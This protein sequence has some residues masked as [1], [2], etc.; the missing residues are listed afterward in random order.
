MNKMT[1]K[2]RFIKT[3]FFAI[4]LI[5]LISCGGKKE[6]P[7]AAYYN[8]DHGLPLQD[9]LL[10]KADSGNYTTLKV[11]FNSVHDKTVYGL[12]SLPENAKKPLP[13]IIL[14]HGVGDRKTVDYIES[15]NSYF[16]EAGYAVFRIDIAN[17]GERKTQN[18]EVDFTGVY[19]YWTRDILSQ[20]VFDLR[21]SIDF[22]STREEIDPE[23]IGFFGISLGGFI[24]TVFCSVD[25]RVKVPVLALAGGG[26][27]ILFG[28]K[29]LNKETANYI[30]IIDP[31]NYV[32][33]ISPRPLLMINAENDDIVPPVTSKLLFKT[34]KEPKKIIWY[35]SKHHDIPIDKVYPDG[36]HWF[37]EYL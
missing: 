22:L 19:K 31:I 2:L 13:V 8:Y 36:I 23:R 28:M 17:H 37:N 16:T 20:T 18:Y 32:E 24:G 4:L 14:L 6:L 33:M 15:G 7:V 27:N 5:S 12:L 10:N 1:G 35:P 25:T 29:A 30:S 26:L 3:T 34:A 11:A 21:R 9:T